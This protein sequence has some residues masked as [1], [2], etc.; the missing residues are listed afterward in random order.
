MAVRVHDKALHALYKDTLQRHGLQH[1]RAQDLVVD[2][3]EDLRHR[4]IDRPREFGFFTRRMLQLLPGRTTIEPVRGLYLWGGVGRGKTMLM[5]L[6]Y[7]SLPFPQRERRHF[8][9]FMH[10]VHGELGKLKQSAHPLE[11]VAHRMANR[12]RIICFDELQVSDIADAMIL[13]TLF[14][15]LFRRGVTLVA[16]SNVAPKNLYKEGLQRQRFLPAIKLIEQHTEVVHVDG[17]VDYRLR[18]LRKAS[19]YLDSKAAGDGNAPDAR[20]RLEQIFTAVAGE[21][22]TIDGHVTIEHRRIKCV[23]QAEDVI[24]FEFHDLCETARSQRDYVEIA[25]YYHTL[26]LSNVPVFDEA[27]ENSA[28]RF[29][30]LVDELYDR[31]VNLI[32]SAAAPPAELYK[33]EKLR[34]EFQRTSSRLIEMQSE[35]YLS[36][37]H[38]A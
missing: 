31:N 36:K 19:I 32:L 18:E 13:A 2:K 14:D 24:W 38:R 6:F 5:D 33:G 28:R 23:R 7:Q 37:A 25:S 9:R 20:A 26:L 16:T 10:E 22:G 27:A 21:P 4:L 8:H 34:F 12:A 17:A 35:Q 1:D 29:I 15:A 30:S 3:L 11:L